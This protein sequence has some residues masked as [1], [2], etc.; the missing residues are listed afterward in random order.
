M[1]GT[2][3]VQGLKGERSISDPAL[4]NLGDEHVEKMWVC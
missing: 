2:G 3:R 1:E 4:D